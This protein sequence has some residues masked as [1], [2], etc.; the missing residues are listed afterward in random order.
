[1]SPLWSVPAACA[2]SIRR[3][4]SWEIPNQGEDVLSFYT[5][6]T[7]KIKKLNQSMQEYEKS[8]PP[9]VTVRYY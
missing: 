8:L 9:G 6:D 1:M 2:P 3:T 5:T 4:A 7:A